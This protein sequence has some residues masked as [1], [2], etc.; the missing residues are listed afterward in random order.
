MHF[1]LRTMPTEKRKRCAICFHQYSPTYRLALQSHAVY[2]E[3][4]IPGKQYLKKIDADELSVPINQK[5]IMKRRLSIPDVH[6]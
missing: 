6:S 3:Y 1:A 2:P 5:K 4:Y